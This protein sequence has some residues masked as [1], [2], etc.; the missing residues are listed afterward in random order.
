MHEC[1]DP[2]ISSLIFSVVS[3]IDVHNKAEHGYF[4]AGTFRIFSRVDCGYGD[5][6]AL[7][8]RLHKV[9]S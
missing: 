7:S 6:E 5:L 3:E 2:A 1:N 8:K 4:A 9:D